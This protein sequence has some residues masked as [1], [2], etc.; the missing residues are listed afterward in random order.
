MPAQGLRGQGGVQQRQPEAA[1]LLGDQEARHAEIR[2]PGPK[3]A[4]HR[5]AAVGEG[6]HALQGTQALERLLQAVDHHPL[7]LREAEIHGFRPP[8]AW[9]RAACQGPARR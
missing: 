7:V 4:R 6:A 8:P 5:F 2:K 9:V 3:V 1:M